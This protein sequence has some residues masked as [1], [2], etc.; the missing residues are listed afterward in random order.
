M[1]LDLKTLL[2]SVVREGGSDLHLTVGIPP[3]MRLNGRLRPLQSQPL[4][5]GD[6]EE[7]VRYLAP[8]KNRLELE[9][10]GTSDFGYSFGPEGRFRVSVYRQK[11]CFGAALRLIP[12]RLLSF[13]EIGL[14][15]VVKNVLQKP[16][17]LLI[18]TGPTGSGK[19]TTLACMV[20]YINER[21]DRHI[22]TIEDPIEYYH[23][24]KRS[25]I[26][27]REIGIDVPSFPEALRRGLRQDPDVILVGEMRDNETIATAIKAA[28]TGHLV[29]GSLHTTGTARTVD[30]I[31]DSFPPTQQEHI[32]SQLAYSIE[33]VISQMLLPRADGTG[34]VAAFEV[35]IKT[36]AVENHIRK[37]ETFKITSVIQT[38]K[39]TGMVMLDDSI[40]GLVQAGKVTLEDALAAAQNPADLYT[41]FG[42]GG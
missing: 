31:I 23:E 38:S 3:L 37:L 2:E 13:E 8:E 24:H 10:T 27:Q 39:K 20:N 28:E 35:M 22:L 14:P 5:A 26:T 30:R 11:G 40:C 19:T 29:L 41:K 7:A 1:T 36:P 34:L 18:V 33:A 16:R 15:P 42:G 17:G 6:T 25:I 21:M 4:K 12:S 32:R 9:G